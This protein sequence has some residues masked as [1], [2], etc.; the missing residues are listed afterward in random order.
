MM[1]AWS[2]SPI[3][4]KSLNDADDQLVAWQGGVA[5]NHEAGMDSL[6]QPRHDQ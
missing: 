5:G 4:G 2:G 3:H 6:L 1:V